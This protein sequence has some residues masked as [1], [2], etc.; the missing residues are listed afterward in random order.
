SGPNV[1]QGY[2][3]KPEET[4][5]VL[6]PDGSFR[7]GDLG[8]LDD[9]GYLF[10][11]GRIKEQYKLETGKYVAPSVLEEQLKLSRYILNVMLYGANKP[12]NVALVVLDVEA[13][14]EW[15]DEQ[16]HRIEDP[17][18]DERVRALIER[19]LARYGSEFKN[20]SE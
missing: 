7:T 9:E 19:E 16:G 11:T 18:T 2:Y 4:A 20:R 3:N 5:A 1:M 15:A 13:V 17:T 6:L 12:Y 8:Y 10:I 14:K